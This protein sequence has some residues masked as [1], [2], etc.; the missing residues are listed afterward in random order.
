MSS[1]VTP[2]PADTLDSPP[3]S[4]NS[5]QATTPLLSPAPSSPLPRNG[6]GNGHYPGN[7]NGHSHNPSSDPPHAPPAHLD[8]LGAGHSSSDN[9]ASPASMLI[10]W[11]SSWIPACGAGLARSTSRSMA[12]AC[13]ALLRSAAA[14]Q[15]HLWLPLASQLHLALFYIFGLYYDLPKRVSGVQYTHIGAAPTQRRYFGAMGVLLLVQVLANAQSLRRC[16]TL[17]CL[18]PA[19]AIQL[20]TWLNT[21]APWCRMLPHRQNRRSDVL[22][23]WASYRTE[24]AAGKPTTCDVEC[25]TCQARQW[26]GASESS[27]WSCH[28]AHQAAIV[29]LACRSR[30]PQ[31]PE[32]ENQR[33]LKVHPA[34]HVS[35][36]QQPECSAHACTPGS[37][38]M[39]V[40]MA[41]RT[42]GQ[43]PLCL[44]DRVV[45]TAL[46]CG[47]LLCWKCAIEW[48][49]R[50]PVCPLCRLGATLQELVP[51]A[52]TVI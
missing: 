38:A 3:D 33:H 30:D 19:C 21:N 26:R 39:G 5:R 37:A 45:P 48:C 49:L 28:R 15:V 17:A 43:C 1:H 8:S 22:A 27:S 18:V 42:Q 10:D 7:G 13:K 35:P 9:Y 47:H 50:K 25:V 46:P 23:L 11:A 24:L 34:D 29:L 44:A 20:L 31:E 12:R 32:Q 40:P 41:S 2:V 36:K 16:V 14:A 52:H 6:D 4:R 51:L